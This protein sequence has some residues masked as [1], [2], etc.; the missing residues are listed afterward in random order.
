MRDVARKASDL[1]RETSGRWL[2]LDPRHPIEI[3]QY[4]RIDIDGRFVPHGNIY[5]SEAVKAAIPD[6]KQ[7]PAK[8][9]EI[10]V[11]EKFKSKEASSWSFDVGPTVS[12]AT[13]LDGSVQLEF[14]VENGRRAAYLIARTS[15]TDYLPTDRLLKKLSSVKELANMYLVTE[16][17]I[18]HGYNFGITTVGRTKIRTQAEATV[19]IPAAVPLTA[20]GQGSFTYKGNS[21]V[22]WSVYGD[23]NEFTYVPTLTMMRM[24]PYWVNKL[25]DYYPFRDALHEVEDKD[26]WIEAT[27]PWAPLDEEGE[28]VLPHD[29]VI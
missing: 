2:N 11:E 13:V 3:G 1:I 16:R 5:E 8:I 21:N 12:V 23:M 10:A 20:G 18:C 4:G 6:I 19:P 28:E 14:E 25:L 26:L 17:T 22:Q 7:H 29:E 15:R 27:P 9:G 24:N